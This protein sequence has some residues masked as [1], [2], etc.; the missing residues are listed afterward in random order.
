M[1]VLG[2]I[3][4]SR[5]EISVTTPIQ[6][7]PNLP[8]FPQ[9]VVAVISGR[10]LMGEPCLGQSHL[11]MIRARS[12]ALCALVALHIAANIISRTSFGNVWFLPHDCSLALCAVGLLSWWVALGCTNRLQALSGWIVGVTV[13]F[14]FCVY[15][16]SWSGNWL[17]I[18]SS[19]AT[20][21]VLSAPA[22][23]LCFLLIAHFLRRSRFVLNG[24]RTGQRTGEQT[25]AKW[26]FFLL[27]IFIFS[28]ALATSLSIIAMLQPYPRWLLD[29]VESIGQIFGWHWSLL[30]AMCVVESVSITAAA[31]WL[32]LGQSHLLARCGVLVLSIILSGLTYS[33]GVTAIRVTIPEVRLDAMDFVGEPVAT[34]L[35]STASFLFLRLSGYRLVC[36]GPVKKRSELFFGR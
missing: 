13:L 14:A 11:S 20:L 19:S 16:L 15:P 12:V 30:F 9:K 1:G 28:M 6:K 32:I 25:A 8:S 24:V 7:Q 27:N 36:P 4:R 5:P 3:L 18:L 23:L 2:R 26:Q 34:A 10:I 17:V 31:S 21:V 22:T 35:M 29:G 33:A